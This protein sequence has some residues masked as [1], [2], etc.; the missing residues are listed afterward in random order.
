MRKNGA[1]LILLLAVFQGFAQEGSIKGPS[2]DTLEQRAIDL[3]TVTVSANKQYLLNK[4]AAID[5]K[6]R[7]LNSSQDVLRMVSGLFIAQHAGGGKAEQ[8]FLRGYD[9]DHGTDINIS[10]DGIPV[11]MVSHAHGQG[12][13]DLHFLIPETVEKANFD[14]G[15]YYANKGNLATAGFVELQTKDFLESNQV[16]L[17]LGQFNTQRLMAMFRVFHKEKDQ[18]RQ[19]FYVA[20]EYFRS[21]GYFQKPQ[22]FHRFNTIGKYNVIFKDNL[23]LTVLGSHLNSKWNASGQIPERAVNSG[24]ISRFGAIDDGEGGDTRRTNISIKLKARHKNNWES[25][26]QFYFTRYHFNLYSNFSFFLND[27]INGDQINQMESRNLLGYSGK[28]AKH[29]GIDHNNKYNTEAGWG[30]RYDQLGNIGLDHVVDRQFLE[31]IQKG[32]LNELNLFGYVDKDLRIGKKFNLN[33]GLRFDHFQFRYMNSLAGETGYRKQERSVFS[34]KLNFAFTPNLRLK[35]YLNSGIGFHSN[36]TR[37]ILDEQADLILPKV[38]GA[39]LGMILKPTKDLVIKTAL[40]YLY[41]EQEFVYVGDE[42]IVEPSGRS[43]RIGLDLSTRL[44]INRWLFADVDLNYAKPRSI[45]EPKGQD[46]VPLAP[47][48]TS[49]GGLTVKTKDKINGSLRYRFIGDRPANEDYTVIA[50]GYMLLDA[51]VSYNWKKIELSVSIENILDREWKEAQFDTNSRMQFESGPVSE[52]H[53]TP[54]TPR[55]VKA[56][57]A[58][59]F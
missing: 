35:F 8:I 33:A 15:P 4:L 22:D 2:N 49:I 52:I 10:V 5:L 53:Y 55:F 20:S 58:L 26:N 57:I 1:F 41:S 21:D 44:Q 32:K 17:Q 43:R 39:D 3:S 24:M 34:P 56:G 50:K 16:K 42:G 30:F 47:T 29:S 48:F 45:D 37:V 7:P 27:P 11:N 40:W 46:R 59:N 19:Q 23:H 18:T 36:D 38:W 25:S 12:Y 31:T 54:G 28:L 6:L 9:I 13:A 51:V 14:K